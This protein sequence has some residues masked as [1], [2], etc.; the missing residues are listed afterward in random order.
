MVKNVFYHLFISLQNEYK[1][2]KIIVNNIKYNT[3]M[4]VVGEEEA[5]KKLYKHICQLFK[6]F[7]SHL[8]S[9]FQFSS[10]VSLYT[11]KASQSWL[12]L[13]ILTKVVIHPHNP[14]IISKRRY[15]GCS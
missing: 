11:H 6:I 7:K 12:S 14:F 8:L 1:Y 10:G 3:Q 13:F 4:Y 9:L 2:Y 15:G 5:A